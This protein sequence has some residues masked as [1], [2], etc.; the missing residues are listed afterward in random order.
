M[1]ATGGIVMNTARL[2][3]PGSR[4]A[5]STALRPWV[6][7]PQLPLPQKV[8]TRGVTLVPRIFPIHKHSPT[9]FLHHQSMSPKNAEN[10]DIKP[11]IQPRYK[12]IYTCRMYE[13][14]S[15]QLTVDVKN[16]LRRHL[17]NI[18]IIMA[19]L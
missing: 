6:R 5:I 16:G 9:N 4:R 8:F 10:E 19:Q 12:I 1:S 13:F 11:Q 2:F 17:V 3:L 18:H 7:Q 15:P 14:T